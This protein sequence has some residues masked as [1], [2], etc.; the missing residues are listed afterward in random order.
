MR[1]H[2]NTNVIGH[3]ITEKM[4]LEHISLDAIRL[5]NVLHRL[6]YS[7]QKKMARC[8]ECALKCDFIL[9]R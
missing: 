1:T 3:L 2:L 9:I 8:F 4:S 6:K 5:Q 7:P